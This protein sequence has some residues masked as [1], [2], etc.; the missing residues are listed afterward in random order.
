MILKYLNKSKKPIFI[1]EISGNHCGSLSMAKK[2]IKTAKKKRRQHC[3]I[4]NLYS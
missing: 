2:L 4:S 1:A 3:Q